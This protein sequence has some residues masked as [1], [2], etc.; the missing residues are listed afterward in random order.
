MVFERNLQYGFQQKRLPYPLLP[1]FFIY[2]KF[3]LLPQRMS[4]QR[5]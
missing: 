2:H 1:P 5:W 3:F 4:D